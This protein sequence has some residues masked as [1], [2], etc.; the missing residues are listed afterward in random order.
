VETITTEK[1]N[2]PSAL[3]P[4]NSLFPYSPRA[5]L[6]PLHHSEIIQ[7]TPENQHAKLQSKMLKFAEVTGNSVPQSKC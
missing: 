1:V 3:N 6:L 2:L 7:H 4:N 5:E